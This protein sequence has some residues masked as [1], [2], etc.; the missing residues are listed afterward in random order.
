MFQLPLALPQLVLPGRVPAPGA[1]Q[2]P[3]ARIPGTALAPRPD[4]LSRT[5]A[6]QV[7]SASLPCGCGLGKAVAGVP[8]LLT[9]LERCRNRFLPIQM[10]LE[11]HETAAE[12]MIEKSQLPS[13]LSSRPLLTSPAALPGAGTFNFC[14]PGANSPNPSLGKHELLCP[15]VPITTVEGPGAPS[16]LVS[17]F[18]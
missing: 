9:F 3:R 17:Y 5:G 4:F 1:G 8:A 12:Y 10:G 13:E 14:P 15:A 16:R 7:T 11:F 2:A 6:T 18:W